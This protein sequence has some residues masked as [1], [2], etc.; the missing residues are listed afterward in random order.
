MA[1]TQLLA[2]RSS[3]TH[4]GVFADSTSVAAF[5]VSIVLLL[6]TLRD[7]LNEM[8][9][10]REMGAVDYFGSIWNWL[11]LS[12]DILLILSPVLWMANVGKVLKPIASITCV[13]LWCVTCVCYLSVTFVLMCV[14]FSSMPT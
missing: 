4:D 7:I 14:Q 6:L 11:D 3:D 8:I 12:S 2:R 9:Q 1:F 10:M 5:V 13:L